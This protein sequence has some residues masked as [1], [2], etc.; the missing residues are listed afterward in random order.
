MSKDGMIH[1]LKWQLQ[2]Q[3]ILIECIYVLHARQDM[4]VA[5][6][7]MLSMIGQYYGGERV[8]I[9][10]FDPDRKWMD[11]TYEW[12]K[13][14]VPSVKD[15]RQHMEISAIERWFPWFE[16]S[17]NYIQSFMRETLG[18]ISGECQRRDF[19]EMENTMAVPLFYGG[20]LMG[21]LGVDNPHGDKKSFILLRSVA[22]FVVHDLFSCDEYQ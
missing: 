1:D 13:A 7:D 12:C 22:R 14:E 10:Q 5:M 17:E 4:E 18:K 19:Q 9:L 2:L 3:N 8:Y 11:N 16:N 20:N 21:L 15:S 6:E